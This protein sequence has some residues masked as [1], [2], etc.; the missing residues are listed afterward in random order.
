MPGQHVVTWDDETP[1]IVNINCGYCRRA[2]TASRISKAIEVERWD[3]L[4]GFGVF[5]VR[6]GVAYVC[7][8]PKC[9]MPSIV[10]MDFRND[11]GD[12]TGGEIVFQ[13]P[14]GKAEPM[15]GLPD[16][17]QADRAESWS[18]FYGG[19]LRASAIMCRATVQRAV[20]SLK[21]VGKG[22][23]AEITDLHGKGTITLTLKEWADEVRILG[24][25]AAHPDTLGKVTQDEAADS[26]K[27]MDAFLEHAIALPA[28]RDQRAAARKP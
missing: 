8:N 2:V 19:D 22:L 20:R 7:E 26:L 12:T 15:D 11:L 23:G 4:P 14:R 5:G 9:R 6:V 10:F 16:E 18:C 13:L 1:D 28:R 27:F 21:A 17:I 3:E 25:D 24:D